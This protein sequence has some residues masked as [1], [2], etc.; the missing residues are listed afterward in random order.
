MVN[1]AQALCVNTSASVHTQTHIVPAEREQSDVN[2]NAMAFFF[3]FLLICSK[4]SFGL[5][6]DLRD[7]HIQSFLNLAPP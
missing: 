6:F 3:F 4:S 1:M 2:N 7:L 5:A